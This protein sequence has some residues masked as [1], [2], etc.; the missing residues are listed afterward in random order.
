VWFE[1]EGRVFFFATKCFNCRNFVVLVT[2]LTTTIIPYTRKVKK[3]K[4]KKGRESRDNP[5]ILKE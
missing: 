2:S 3:K 4:K 1:R 5:N